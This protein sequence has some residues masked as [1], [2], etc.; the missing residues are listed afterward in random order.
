LGRAGHELEKITKRSVAVKECFFDSCMANPAISFDKYKF[1][2][3]N[4]GQAFF[5]PF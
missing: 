1:E 3:K 4:L 5:L 2:I